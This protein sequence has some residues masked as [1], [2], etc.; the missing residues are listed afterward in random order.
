MNIKNRISIPIHD[1][2]GISTPPAVWSQRI[3]FVEEDQTGRGLARRFEDLA[4]ILF[5]LTDVHVQQLG[6]FDAE[7]VQA[8]FSCHS[9]LQVSLQIFIIHPIFSFYRHLRQVAI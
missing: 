6:A 4:Y 9:C 2:A 3:E 7:E 5:T 8:A 1:T